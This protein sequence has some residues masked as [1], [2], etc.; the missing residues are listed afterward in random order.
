MKNLK[1]NHPAA[2][3]CIIVLHVL[4]FLW[5]GPLFGESWMRM[6]GL[7]MANMEANDPGIAVWILNFISCAASVYMLAWLFTKLDVRSG[8]RGAGI[9]FLIAL[10][11]HHFWTM[12]GNMFAGEPYALAWITGGYSLASLSICGF[13][14]GAW[15]KSQP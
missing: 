5:Y 3:V 10:C 12:S 9:G 8:I 11:F 15:T 6:V 1:I 14:L 2:V 7:D 4:G 13:I